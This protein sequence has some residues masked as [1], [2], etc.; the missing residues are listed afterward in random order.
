MKAHPE[1]AVTEGRDVVYVGR[2]GGSNPI[3][4]DSR[5]RKEI[6]ASWRRVGMSGERIAHD[7]NLFF[8]NR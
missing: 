8:A 4:E 6:A 7:L 3:F 1:A 5:S 2:D